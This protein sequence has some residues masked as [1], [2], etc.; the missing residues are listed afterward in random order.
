VIGFPE[1]EKELK[2]LNLR[3]KSHDKRLLQEME[4]KK[5]CAREKQVQAIR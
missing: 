4:R 2:S 1:L 5:K 3:A